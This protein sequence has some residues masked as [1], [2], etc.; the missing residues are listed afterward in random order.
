MKTQPTGAGAQL[1]PSGGRGEEGARRERFEQWAAGVPFRLKLAFVWLGIFVVFGVLFWAAKFDTTWMRQN[2]VFVAKGLWVTIFI[3][4]VSIVGAIVLALLGALGRLSRNPIAYGVTGFY[5]SFFRGTPLIVQLYLIYFAL[6]QLGQSLSLQFRDPYKSWFVTVT[7]LSPIA[8]GMVG[9]SLNYGAY[10]TEIFRAG[11][12]S[13]SHGQAEAAD[14]LGMTY[15]QKMRRVVLPQALRV[16][17]PPTG[18]EFIAMMKDTALIG[19]LGST[20]FWADPFRRATLLGRPVFKNLE[21]LLVAAACYWA[22]TA[23]FTFFQQ[24][25][26]RRM[27]RGYVRAVAPAS[28][29]G[30]VRFVPGSAA[31]GYGSGAMMVEVPEPD[32]PH[33]DREDTS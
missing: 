25:L 18:N 28:A 24:R 14:A 13:V 27:S 9:L 3:A 4:T 23:I 6:P 2:L 7:L 8:A 32:D 10:M 30:G 26:E 5:T 15:R 22:L 31:G 12:Q 17:I 20:L 19:F 16:I 1:P 11:I 33:P 21:A 29:H